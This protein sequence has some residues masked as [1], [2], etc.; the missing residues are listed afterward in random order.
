MGRRSVYGSGRN[1]FGGNNGN[2]AGA[3]DNGNGNNVAGAFDNG[4][5]NVETIIEPTENI[6]NTTTNR[7]TVRRV[8]PTHIENVN[9]TIVRV[10]NYFPVTES[11]VNET[12]VEEYNCGSDLRNPCC[13]PVKRKCN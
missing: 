11:N 9:R 12:F 4:G 8:Y 10:E 2:V 1:G 13:K 3:F 7:R 6:V 5:N